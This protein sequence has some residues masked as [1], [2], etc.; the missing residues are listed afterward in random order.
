MQQLKQIKITL[1]HSKLNGEQKSEH[2][3]KPK[4]KKLI[5]VHFYTNVNVF[6]REYCV[7]F[8]ITKTVCIF[9]WDNKRM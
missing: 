4:F 8:F 9:Y 3:K 7:S 1:K 5:S 6:Y 2:P